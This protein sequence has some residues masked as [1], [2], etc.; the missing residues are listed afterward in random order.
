MEQ[1]RSLHY[2]VEKLVR[3]GHLRQ[4]IHSEGKSE[5]TSQSLAT[6]APTTSATPR[7]VINYIHGGPVDEECNFKRKRQRIILI[8]SIMG[9]T[10]MHDMKAIPSTYHQMVSYLIEDEQ[11][12][13]YGSQLAV[14]QCYQVA[15]EAGSS[16]DNESSTKPADSADQ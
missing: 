11:I 4:Y 15:R 3:V 8:Q 6:T 10:W 14:R 1:F 5:E 7:V 16:S 9:R 2:L 12:N 13:L